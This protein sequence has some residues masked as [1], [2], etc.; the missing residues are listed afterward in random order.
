VDPYIFEI[1]AVSSISPDI[2]ANKTYRLSLSDIISATLKRVD[3]MTFL[4]NYSRFVNYKNWRDK[5]SCL[6]EFALKII[7][8]THKGKYKIDPTILKYDFYHTDDGCEYSALMRGIFDSK[9]VKKHHSCFD[10]LNLLYNTASVQIE[11]PNTFDR[12]KAV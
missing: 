1:D 3:Y 4:G 7:N 8:Y 6:L 10:V 11:I 2:E 12:G 5:Y 9:N